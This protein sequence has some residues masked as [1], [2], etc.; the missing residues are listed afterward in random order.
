MSPRRFWLFRSKQPLYLSNSMSL[1][2]A[3]VRNG[4]SDANQAGARGGQAG[5]MEQKGLLLPTGAPHFSR[6]VRFFH[7]FQR[8]G[9]EVFCR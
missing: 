2:R 3:M 4:G 9:K 1:I 6:I 5:K 7:A 8:A